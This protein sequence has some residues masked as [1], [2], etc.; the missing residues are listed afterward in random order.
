M[1]DIN[2]ISAQEIGRR[3]RLARENAGIRQ[4]QAAQLLGI[5]RPT[6]VSIEKGMRRVRI[7]ELQHLAH[8]Y[9]ISVNALLRREAVHSD[10]IP[11]FRKL[12][13]TE[14]IHTAEAVKVL[15]DL[16]KAEVELENVLGVERKRNYPP[17]RGISVGDINDLA[18][19]HAQELRDW[20]GLGYGPIPD[21]FSLIEFDLGIRLYQRRLSTSSRVAGLFAYDP[22]IGACILLNANHPLERR[23][24]SAAHELGHF[25]GA[26]QI[27]EVL[28]DN[29]RFLSRDERYANAFG[30]T[31]L[32]PVKPFKDSFKEL[33][34]GADRL[35]R[36]HVI[37][38]AHQHHI[39]REA[40]VRRLEELSLVKKGTWDWFEMNGGITDK[41]AIAVLGDDA[42]RRDLAKDAADHPLSHRMSLMVYE[43]WKRDLMSEGQLAELLKLGRVE[44]RELVDQFELEEESTD[45]LLNL[46]R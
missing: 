14:D 30:R 22:D 25:M 11:R 7:H 42:Q 33:T 6:L 8:H 39:S 18:E 26:R 21:I 46:P 40:C 24:Q 16:V 17:E 27:P 23:V 36:R 1:A 12:Q 41:D 28:E 2:E 32:T 9:G 10:L 3:L 20:V 15:N 45:D 44:L 35:L 5:S 4:D 29:E 34:A 37:L 19:K 38:L 13:Q 31:F 43:T